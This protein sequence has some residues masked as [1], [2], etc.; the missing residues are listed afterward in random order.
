MSVTN[1]FNSAT[2]KAIAV[3]LLVMLM[4]IPLAQ[5]RSLIGEREGL[6]R[7]AQ[8]RIAAGIGGIQRIGGPVISVPSET[9]QLMTDENT[10]KR[11]ELWVE[12]P[13]LRLLPK[14]LSIDADLKMQ[15]RKKGIYTLPVYVATV[16][17]QG[18]FD[19]E[20]LASMSPRDRPADA[21]HP[22]MRAHP[23]RAVLLLPLG[24]LKSLRAVQQMEFGGVK[25]QPGPGVLAGGQALQM[26]IDLNQLL[27]SR[28]TGSLAFR[29]LVDISGSEAIRFVPLAAET[30]A[31]LRSNWP[32]PDFQGAFLPVD[33]AVDA[34]GSSARWSVLALN[35]PIAQAW[36]GDGVGE[37]QLAEASFGV[38]LMQPSTVYST[39]ERAVRY[40]ILFIAITFLGFFGW[41]HVAKGLRL[42]SM[43]YLLVGLAL[44]VFYLLLIALSEHLGFGRAYACAAS[45]LVALI[46]SYVAGATGRIAAT[47]IISLLLA[48]SYGL[49][50]L[51]LLSEDY[52][53]LLGSLLVFGTLATLMLATRKLDWSRVA[54]PDGTA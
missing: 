27:A 17:I 36:Y 33:S 39:N 38:R 1:R 15:V 52:A 48:I 34:H 54:A 3:A 45:A 31:K 28:L 26:P 18:A 12:A 42:H 43:Q 29:F 22:A 53:L 11:S 51:I 7:E 25:L 35:R 8:N 6:Q 14:T 13:A 9:L 23:D 50:Y 32:H 30:T 2:L 44:T 20:F 5:V 41:E 37:P 19:R 10:H 24:E 21:D 49:L 40:G 47:L 16:Q 4:V 46:G